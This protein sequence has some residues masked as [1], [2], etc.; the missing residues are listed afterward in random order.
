M[1]SH[2]VYSTNDA[3]ELVETLYDEY[4]DKLPSPDKIIKWPFAEISTIELSE[5]V[6]RLYESVKS[7][8]ENLLVEDPNS[9]MDN[10]K[11]LHRLIKSHS[12]AAQELEKRPDYTP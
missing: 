4:G 12:R 7:K 5:H 1:P 2:A 11:S 8:T 3:G 6:S 10:F 9:W